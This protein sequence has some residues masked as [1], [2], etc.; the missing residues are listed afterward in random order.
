MATE[1]DVAASNGDPSSPVDYEIGWFDAEKLDS[2]D[3]AEALEQHIAAHT[4]PCDIWAKLVANAEAQDQPGLHRGGAGDGLAHLKLF[5]PD[6]NATWYLSEV[7]EVGAYEGQPEGTV[8]Y[9]LFGLCDLGLGFP[10]LGY[11]SL[12]ELM[13]LKGPM[14][15][16]VE[17]DLC[18]TPTPLKDLPK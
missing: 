16:A 6:G 12:T 7:R 8:N 2:F 10:E 4:I 14:G 9:Q 13:E 1:Q 3:S 17:R 5:T 11:V 18:W 15:L